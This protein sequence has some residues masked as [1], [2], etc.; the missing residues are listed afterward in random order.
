MIPLL[1]VASPPETDPV[2]PDTSIVEP[3]VTRWVLD[4]ADWT[5]QRPWLLG[6][7]ACLLLAWIAARTVVAAWRHRHHTAGARLVT[8]APPPL[9]DESSAAALWANLAGIL[10]PSRHRRLIFG[11]PHV[12]WQYTWTGRHLLISLWVPG[13]VPQGAVEAAVRAAWP[14]AAT[15]TEPAR[16]PVPA[17]L[18]AVGGHL[19]PVAP[20][21]L[22]LQ[23]D[24]D[25][26]P[27]RALMAAGAQLHD[28]EYACVQI[29]AR[30]AAPRR[31]GRARRAA[32]RLRQGKAAAP[33]INP[34]AP[35][36][37]LLDLLLPGPT[38]GH[39]GVPAARRDPTLD[40]DVR[41]I[42]DKTAHQLWETGV[43]Y[44]VAGHV[45]RDG[46]RPRHRLRGV[47]DAIAS[48]F[49]VYAGRNRL[50]HRSRMPRPVAVLAARRLG[51]GFLT[52]AP[53]LAAMAALPRDL[54]VPGLDRA[55]AK[56]MPVPVAVPSGGRNRKVLGEA[57]VGGHAVAL[58]VPDARYHTHMVGQT[59]SGK[60]T[61]LANLIIDDITAGRGTIVLDPHGDLVLDVLDRLPASVAD[62]VVLF[63]PAQPNPP[64]LNPLEG[65]D[66]DLVVDNLVS[67]FGSI[68]SKA[69]GPRMDDV[70]RVSCL[71]LLRHANVTLQHIPP[72]LNSAQFRSA[73]TVD[74]DDPDGL[75]GFWQWFDELSPALRSQIIGPVLARLRAF[76]L[77]DFVRRTM[78]FPKSSFDMGKILDGGVLLVRIPKGELGED[79][80]RLL[81]S[82]I[83]ARVW[84]AATARASVPAERRKDCSIYLDEAQ[85]FL[86]LAAS[87][88]TMLA[89][90]RK[91]RLAM[92]LAHQDLAQFPR[93]LL[94]AISANARNK[95]FFSVAPEDA[96]VLARHTLPELD[97]HD[98]THLDVYTAVARLLVD[99][100]Q[101]PA[102]TMRTRR[103]RPV[104][105]EATAIRQRVSEAVPAQN[106][107]AVDA[108]VKQYSQKPD[109][110]RRRN[111]T[112]QP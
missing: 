43:R 106:A 55:R 49:A 90:A 60:T 66:P 108:L 24:H 54:A 77:R 81:G 10:T 46:T 86:T 57:E 75:H 61:L 50:A 67:I 65:D 5:L 13:T 107:S 40:R 82:L 72:L 19:L 85:N 83:L 80:S 27:L 33:S 18:A 101:A 32:G 56:S 11:T 99:G 109:D 89:E 70:M 97:E 21:W 88:D 20:E 16:D 104:I 53:E 8:I 71:T 103:P 44:A 14:G 6:V 76:L 84:Q 62:R 91:Y 96:R 98:L 15:T 58:S 3:P 2:D 28:R 100:R 37:A 25:A 79:T 4:A 42:L 59:G 69:W 26:D 87:L 63:D 34:A 7:A 36:A 73:M 39:T 9:V 78:R 102:F 41:A 17:D 94:A 12:T 35:V 112:K 111:D 1:P 29:L 95:I 45:H 52:S 48:S 47:A 92:T 31:A 64:A 93:E 23:S 51:A 22:P 38:R 74:L 30:P 68:F 110:R 105:G